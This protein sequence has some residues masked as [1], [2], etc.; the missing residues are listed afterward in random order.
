[1]ATET[2][3]R[4]D[5]APSGG[6]GGRRL[7]VLALG[8]LGVVYGDIGTS[9]LYA[10]RESFAAHEAVE[11]QAANI[12]GVLSLIVWSLIIVI[13][14]KYLVFVLRADSDGEGGILVLTSLIP[15]EGDYH[16]RG[17]RRLLI[18]VGIFGTAL[19]YGDG[20][21]TPAISVLSAV[22]GVRVATQALDPYVIPIACGILVVL[23]AFQPRGT[24]AI[25]SVF[26]PVM[27][28]WF[29]VLGVLGA[30]G[31]LRQ[32]TVLRA[33]NPAYGLAFFAD[34]GLP[35]LLVLGSVFLVVTGGEA[36]YADLGH[37]GKRPIQLAWFTIVLPGLLLNYFGQGALLL[38]HPEAADNP[39]YRLA[40]PWA[41]IPLVLLATAATVI[42]SQAL[43]SGA[44]SLTMQ[45]VQMGY[46]PR[47][48]IH[49]TSEEEMGQIYI[50]AVNWTLMVACI[51]LV[52]GFRTSGN[53]AAA[54]G[55]AV[56]TTMVVTTLLF[57]VVARERFEWPRTRTY[58]LCAAFLVVDLGFFVANLFKI[59]DGGW[60]PI[61]AGVLV[62]TA[63]TTWKRG[64][65]LVAR[66]IRKGLIP[67][68]QFLRDLGAETRVPDAAIYLSAIE[69]MIPPSLITNLRHNNSLHEQILL[70]HVETSSA[71]HVPV[72]R[73]ADIRKLSNGFSAVTLRFGFTDH[74]DVPDALHR[75][76]FDRLGVDESRLTYV[77][78]RENVLATERPGMAIWRE[79]L[80]AVMARNSTDVMRFFRL[81]ADKVIEI[82]RP[83]EI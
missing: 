12:L 29:T 37:F 6:N 48:R 79:R 81:P 4:A 28:T 40:P 39:F 60:F 21:I 70:V 74:I 42:A 66:H 3:R 30:V 1:L 43:I 65:M 34:N 55:V 54:Y 77:V 11:V 23:F 18:L 14:V 19:L 8:A 31:V 5:G 17:R 45:A 80:F 51:G 71:P 82:G 63:M 56:T 49:Q 41:Q 64:R 15:R 27:L 20:A 52:L 22:E 24:E 36:L 25:G 32:P 59:P 16:G 78:G 69:G 26:G 44:F 61:I 7:G 72:Q 9:P 53:L 33:F 76:V 46:L 73:C 58:A 10:F 35:G 83:V 57:A 50:P 62:F 2:E 67:V 68:E 38:S 75:R 47:L 13:S